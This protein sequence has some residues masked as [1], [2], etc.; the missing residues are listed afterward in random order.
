MINRKKYV[1]RRWCRYK[2]YLNFDINFDVNAF[3]INFDV[4][5]LYS[6]YFYSRC[7]TTDSIPCSISSYSPGGQSTCTTCPIGHECPT[8]SLAAPVP[9]AGG[10]YSNT[11]GTSTCLDCPVGYSCSNSS[12]TPIQCDSGMYSPGK[13]S[14]CIDCPQGY[15]YVEDIC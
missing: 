9:C 1:S 5:A 4:N 7:N 2:I 11:T 6:F 3:D 8:N 14:D 10:T 15:R 13:C 12:I